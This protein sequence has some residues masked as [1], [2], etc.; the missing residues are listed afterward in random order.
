[1]LHFYFT[2]NPQNIALHRQIKCQA[3]KCVHVNWFFVTKVCIYNEQRELMLQYFLS[4][5]LCVY[6]DGVWVNSPILIQVVPQI[7]LSEWSE[8]VLE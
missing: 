5:H 7:S 1:M 6:F 3:K 4:D 8:Q 2:Q